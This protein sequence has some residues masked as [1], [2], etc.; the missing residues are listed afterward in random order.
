MKNIFYPYYRFLIQNKYLGNLRS[1]LKIELNHDL[2]SSKTYVFNSLDLG[3][4][5]QSGVEFPEREF[6][7][8]GEPVLSSPDPLQIQDESSRLRQAL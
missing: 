1:I 7:S 4:D 6:V 3:S 5:F 8:G 2:R